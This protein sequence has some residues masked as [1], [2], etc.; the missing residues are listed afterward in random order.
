MKAQG[1]SPSRYN[2]P[3]QSAY[4]GT[5]EIYK[6]RFGHRIHPPLSLSNRIPYENYDLSFSTVMSEH[7]NSKAH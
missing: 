3:E 7:V 6:A 4:L 2:G 5:K 1:R